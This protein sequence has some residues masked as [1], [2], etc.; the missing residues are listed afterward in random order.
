MSHHTEADRMRNA[1]ERSIVVTRVFDAPRELVFRAFTDPGM[2]AK[3]FAPEPFTVPSAENELRIGGRYRYVMR[4][5]D[6][7]EY[8][9]TGVFKEIKEPERLV[10][11]DSVEEMPSSWTD[12][13]NEARG[14]P[15]GTP[16]PDGVVT[17]KL[18]DADGKTKVTFWDEF[19]SQATRDAYVKQQMIEGLE[20]TFDQ[21][22]K[23]LVESR[24]HV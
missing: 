13:V 18:E 20:G 6:G 24:A 12:Q 3:W 23:T 15:K 9:A 1:E 7:D 14:E 5:P 4:G 8:P 22:E 17:I 11:T 19:D 10:Y 2:V 21:L 16:I